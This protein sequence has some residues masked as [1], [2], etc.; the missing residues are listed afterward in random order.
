MASWTPSGGPTLRL[1][2]ALLGL[3]IPALELLAVGLNFVMFH[4][5]IKQLVRGAVEAT[6]WWWPT[7]MLRPHHSC[8]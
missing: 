4:D 7:L 6:A 2:S 5:V 3:D 8:W 1:D